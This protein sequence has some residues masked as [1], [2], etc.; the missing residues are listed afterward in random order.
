MNSIN[1]TVDE[2][3]SL[4]EKYGNE[5]YGE[6]VTQMEHMLQSALLAQEEASDEES[7][8]AAFLHD[9]GHLCEKIVETSN[10]GDFG[11][12]NHEAYGALFLQE[13]GF[14]TK[15]V[16]SI[17]NHVNAKRYLVFKDPEY[18]AGLSEASKK[19]L[20]YQGGPMNATEATRFESDPYF[21][22]HIKLRNWDDQA[23]VPGASQCLLEEMKA[24]MIRH[25]EQHYSSLN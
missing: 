6:N 12:E 1:Q 22:F 15:I 18:L 2:I 3:M 8:L 20:E 21:E 24:M 9:I 11:V 13:K 10:M 17:A 23:K 7:V 14:S 16:S 5:S 25:L 4:Y 19:T